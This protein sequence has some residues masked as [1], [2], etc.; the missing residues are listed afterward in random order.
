MEALIGIAA[1][2]TA[3]VV[4]LGIGGHREPGPDTNPHIIDVDG[5]EDALKLLRRGVL[6]NIPVPVRIPAL[7]DFDGIVQKLEDEGINLSIYGDQRVVQNVLKIPKIRKIPGIRESESEPE[8]TTTVEIDGRT[9]RIVLCSSRAVRPAPEPVPAP[10]APAAAR[11]GVVKV[12]IVGEE[13]E[14]SPDFCDYGIPGW[15]GT[16]FY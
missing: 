5:L 3:F 12:R 6:L 16:D 13:P 14:Y 9:V 10:P 2:A 11:N 7:L 15:G 8:H 4:I 1:L